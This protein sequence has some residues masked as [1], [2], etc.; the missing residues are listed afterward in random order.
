MFVGERMNRKEKSKNIILWVVIFVF[1]ATAIYQ[2]ND[3]TR[4]YRSVTVR[5]QDQSITK[6]KIESIL[7]EEMEEQDAR[8]VA[9]ANSGTAVKLPDI[10]AYEK[11]EH[12]SV[13]NDSVGKKRQVNRYQ[14]CGNMSLI[15]PS[16]LLCGNYV[17]REDYEGCVIDK[18]TAY[19]LY[20]SYDIIGQEI[21]VPVINQNKTYYIRGILSITQ[22]TIMIQTKDDNVQFYSMQLDYGNSS[23]GREYT[24]QLLMVYQIAAEYQIVDQNLIVRVTG[25]L[26]VLPWIILTIVLVTRTLRKWKANSDNHRQDWLHKIKSDR[27][28]IST[29]VCVIMLVVVGKQYGFFPLQ[30][31]PTKWSDF[32]CVSRIIALIQAHSKEFEFMVLF[33]REIAL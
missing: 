19:Q 22:P 28:I 25:N 18:E 32:N 17:Y 12:V 13:A 16:E 24:E 33:M 1:Y 11:E 15:L 14:V 7:E 23:R 3:M 26:F 9:K 21:T 6:E 2:Y 29:G 27:T 4:N 31:I 20:G 30:Y 5:L 8:G 10:T